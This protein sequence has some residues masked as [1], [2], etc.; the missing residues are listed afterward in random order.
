MSE[1]D[2]TYKAIGD[3]PVK[4]RRFGVV[5]IE[6]H[7][8]PEALYDELELACDERKEIDRDSDNEPRPTLYLADFCEG[9]EEFEEWARAY[10]DF[11]EDE[12]AAFEIDI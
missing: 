2:A 3:Q 7:E 5:R 11:G 8:I 4:T 6:W 1:Q 12:D 10:F 9:S